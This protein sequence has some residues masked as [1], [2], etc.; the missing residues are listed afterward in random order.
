MNRQIIT[1]VLLAALS[2]GLPGARAGAA[3]EA[4]PDRFAPPDCGAMGMMP[5]PGELLSHLTRQLGLNEDQQ[6]K[7][8]A[9]LASDREKSGPLQQKLKEQLKQLRSAIE[10]EPYD[11]A[12]V[13]AV[14]TRKV[15]IEVELIVSQ[16][17]VKSRINALLTPEQKAQAEKQPPAPGRGRGPHPPGGGERSSHRPPPPP[18]DDHERHAGGPDN[19]E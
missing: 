7:V 16:A 2:V 5:P 11:E 12:T 14:A 1:A 3:D 10:S 18:C 13:R 8:M 9:I 19:G 17:R 4:G 6:T 15:Q